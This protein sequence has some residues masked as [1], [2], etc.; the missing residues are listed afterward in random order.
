VTFDFSN[1]SEVFVH[2]RTTEPWKGTIVDTG[3][4]T[5]TGVRIK[6]VKKYVGDEP[7][8]LT[9]GDGVSDVN[10]SEELKYHERHG[11]KVT[12]SAYNMAQRFGVLELD[13]DGNV[14]DFREKSSGDDNLVNIGFMI[15]EPEVIEWID[16][17]N[18]NFEKETLEYAAKLGE[19]KAYKH[20]GYWQCMD[21]LREKE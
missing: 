18:T 5:L 7:F 20:K 4:Y 12:I 2:H 1:G 19:L 17:D 6:R 11:K 8:F 16:G 21:T 13:I 3:L 15:C 9:Y 10:I 14:Q